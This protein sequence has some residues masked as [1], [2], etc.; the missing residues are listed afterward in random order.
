MKYSAIPKALA[1]AMEG[2]ISILDDLTEIK[3]K[4]A[5]Y[6]RRRQ[7]WEFQAKQ[8]KTALEDIDQTIEIQKAQIKSAT[9]ALESIKREQ[10]LMQEKYTFLRK[11]FTNKEQLLDIAQHLAHSD[12][13][14]HFIFHAR[15]F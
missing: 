3:E 8:A 13:F 7:E 14:V 10:T 6:E 1:V 4:N 11:R 5:T 9:Y 15:L 12:R 2:A